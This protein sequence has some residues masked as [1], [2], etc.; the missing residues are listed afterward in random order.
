MS[1]LKKILSSIRFNQKNKQ[2]T[3]S[4]TNLTETSQI[5]C[6]SKNSFEKLVIIFKYSNR[7]ISNQVWENFQEDAKFT[8]EEAIFYFLNVTTHEALSTMISNTFQVLH[9]APQLIVIHQGK[10]VCQG[11]HQA[12]VPFVIHQLLGK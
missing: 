5:E 2:K 9:Q 6:I 7:G 11:S 8:D 4:V 3:F 12:A 1:L 10:V